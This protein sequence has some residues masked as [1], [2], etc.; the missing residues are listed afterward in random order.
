MVWQAESS[1]V[2]TRWTITL[3]DLGDH[4]HVRVNAIFTV[5]EATQSDMTGLASKIR[6]FKQNL[7]RRVSQG[8]PRP[9]ESA[10]QASV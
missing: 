8:T 1:E 5:D 4:T 6:C 7:L 2:G 3:D 10:S 9:E